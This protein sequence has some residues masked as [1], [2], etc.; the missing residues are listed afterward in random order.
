MFCKNIIV[1]AGFAGSVLARRIAEEKNEDVLIIEKHN[2]IAGHAFDFYNEVGI[3]IHMYGPHIFHTTMK[4]VWDWMS[5]FTSWHYYQHRV[6]SYVDGML[7]PM[8]ISTETINQLL[9]LSLDTDQIVHWFQNHRI[10]FN[11]ITNS[12]E[13]ILS[14]AGNLVYEKFFKNYTRKQW[15]RDAKDLDAS[16]TK[17]IPIRQSRDTRYF[18]DQY[19]A[20][21]RYGYSSLFNAIL[22]HPKIH[23]MLNTK[24]QFVQNSIQYD[25]LYYSGCLDEFFD[26]CF[27]KLPYRSVRFEY[28][29]IHDCEQYQQVGV[30]NYPNDYD[31][32]RITE[33]KHFSGQKLPHTTIAREYS[34]AEGEPFYIIPNP[35]YIQLA[36]KYRTEAKKLGNVTFIGRLAEYKYYNMDQVVKQALTTPLG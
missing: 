12:E 2:H 17:R 21:P 6:L 18:T 25:H 3:L 13:A 11:E 20:I 10:S 28:E 4:E 5:R 19:Q 8:P 23:V 1:G 22:D 9:N 7:I 32:T 30:V 16:I 27:G 14:Q 33:Y 15:D 35:E 26:H 36:E 34:T 31:F 24:W 29:T